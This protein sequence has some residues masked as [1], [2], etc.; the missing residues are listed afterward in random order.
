MQP[1]MSSGRISRGNPQSADLK[2]DG[3]VSDTCHRL[4]Y[5]QPFDYASVLTWLEARAIES[6]EEVVDG[7]YRRVVVENGKIG[8]I[9]VANDP[10]ASSL[11]V[12]VRQP[13]VRGVP[14]ILERVRRAFDLDANIES[15]EAVLS[16]DASLGPLVA[17]RPGLRVP[18]GWDPFELATRAV[19]GQQVTVIAARRLAGQL[20]ALCGEPLHVKDRRA[21]H[22]TH[23]FPTPERLASADL[24]AL[25]MP[26][27]RRATLKALAEATLTDRDLFGSRSLE[28][29]IARLRSI[30]GIGEWTA[31]YI[32]LRG[33]RQ[34]DAFPANDVG[35]LRGAAASGVRPTATALLVRAEAWRPWRAYAAQHLWA[36]DAARHQGRPLGPAL[37]DG[38]PGVCSGY[39]LVEFT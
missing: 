11:T 12:V 25:G 10:A 19:L 8:I 2:L 39:R 6:V 14:A 32:A 22:L 36:A 20:V 27:A 3:V 17:R 35:I 13:A 28:E 33:L 18:G 9:D 16:R 23:A 38:A 30:R 5:E 7:V 15:V 29:T 31:Q 1:I 34:P 21:I 37:P 26:Q 4:R 24:G